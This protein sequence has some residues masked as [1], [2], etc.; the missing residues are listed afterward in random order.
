MLARDHKTR[1]IAVVKEL[2]RESLDPVMLLEYYSVDIPSR[3]F[4]YDKVRCAC[5]IHGGDNPSGF[6]FDLNSKMFTCFTSHCGEQPSDWW[7]VPKNSSLVP[8]DLFLFI[9]MMEEKRA[10]EEGRSNFKC[11]FSRALEVASQITGIAI[12]NEASTYNKEMLDQLDNKKWMRQMAKINKEVELDIVSEDEIEIFKAQLP[13]CYEYLET[14]NFDLD[15]IEFFELGFSTDGVDEPWNVGKR[16]FLGRLVFPVRDH[17]GNLVGWSG[18][19]PTDDKRLTK[20]YNKFMHKMD[21]E[22]GFV[23]YNYHNAKPYIKESKE[24][25]LVE[26]IW[27]VMRLW[28][29]GIRNVVAVLGSSL[30][31]EQ[32]SLAVS[33][34][35]KAKVFLDGDG[36]GKSGAK[37]ICDMLKRYVDVYTVESDKDPDNLSIDEAYIAIAQ[38]KKHI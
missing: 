16:D 33:S 24:I 37:R 21:F 25:I 2:I 8:R 4:R 22:K 13:L 7:F 34:A 6:S 11:S 12:D 14:R 10:Y 15:T 20:K 31:P 19:L 27:D 28:S 30:T 36:A 35:I 18:R 5:P 1:D 3:N 32:L 23:L 17:V 9:K 38:A 26:G 29:Y